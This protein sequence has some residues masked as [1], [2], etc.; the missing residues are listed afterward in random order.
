MKA[1]QYDQFTY[2][3]YEKTS[4]KA[5]SFQLTKEDSEVLSRITAYT[6]GNLLNCMRPNTL[7]KLRE[8]CPGSCVQC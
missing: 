1:D 3:A 6:V 4:A 7:Q 5:L 8:T 2:T